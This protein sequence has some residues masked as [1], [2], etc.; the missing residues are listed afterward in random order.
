MKK[1]YFSFIFAF[2]MLV[3]CMLLLTACGGKKVS[4][5]TID[6]MFVGE[7]QVEYQ[8]GTSIND[9]ISTN[10]TVTVNYDDNSKKVL[11]PN[12]YVVKYYKD[13][14]EVDNFKAIPDVGNYSIEVIYDTSTEINTFTVVPSYK[15]PYEINLT[16]NTWAYCNELPEISL[17]NYVLKEGE[18]VD[19]FYI[20]KNAFEN[21]T[22]EQKTKVEEYASRWINSSMYVYA[23]EYYVFGKINFIEQ[24]NYTGVTKIDNNCLITVTKQTI[25]LSQNLVNYYNFIAEYTFAEDTVNINLGDIDI[26]GDVIYLEPIGDAPI[27]GTLQWLNPDQVITIDNNGQSFPVKFI[28]FFEEDNLNYNFEGNL[29]LQVNIKRDILN[30]SGDYQSVNPKEDGNLKPMPK[31][32]EYLGEWMEVGMET[33]APD[34]TANIQIEYTDTSTNFNLT[35]Q[36]NNQYSDT[37][38]YTSFKT[39]TTLTDGKDNYVIN[40]KVDTSD[41]NN[42]YTVT[43]NG[44]GTNFV[45]DENLHSLIMTALRIDLANNSISD[46]TLIYSV[47]QDSE[48]LKI[49]VENNF[50][51]GVIVVHFVFDVEGNFVG[52]KVS[53]TSVDG[54]MSYS[55]QMK[56]VKLN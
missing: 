50:E 23:G 28:P 22:E 29:T 48:N 6:N 49:K 45:I 51:G 7:R 26:I 55:I 54:T 36:L 30:V 38:F 16:K 24:S 41:Q 47:A 46:E 13:S 53:M 19:W 9:I 42:E 4:S 5:I 17:S 12:E 25:T 44:E 27:Q 40:G 11:E 21:L 35:G 2:I 8:Y 34:Y 18:T 33:T 39:N 10:L 20:E 56:L 52:H 37:S 1:N 31:Y 43:K 15:S 32:L 3:P 14:V